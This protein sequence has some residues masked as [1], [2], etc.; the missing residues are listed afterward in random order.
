MPISADLRLF[1]IVLVT[2]LAIAGGLALRGALRWVVLFGGLLVAAYL[3]GFLPA[4][5]I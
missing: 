5:R 1:A 4:V 3:A 2:I